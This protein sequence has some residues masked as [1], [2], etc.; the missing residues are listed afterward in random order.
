MTR[1]T[2]PAAYIRISREPGALTLASQRSAVREAARS[3]G[4]AEPAEYL[5]VDETWP[6]LARLTTAI[7][8]GQ[9]DSLLI[10]VGT[11]V[12]IPAEMA[13]LLAGCARHGVAVECITPCGT[14]AGGTRGSQPR[15]SG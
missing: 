2:R 5:D 14:G 15:R 12:G 7:S 4:W 8:T 13:T 10:G 11:I 9:H 1:G 6:A 3:R